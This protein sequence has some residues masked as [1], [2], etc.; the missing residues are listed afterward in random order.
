MATYLMSTTVIPASAFGAW[1]MD[2]IALEDLQVLLH[3]E[4]AGAGYTSAVGHESTAQIMAELLG[5]PVAAN[6]ITVEPKK[7]DVFYCFKLD[8]RPPEGA[9]LDRSQ[10]E[11]LGYSWARMHYIG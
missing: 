10:L 9:I 2:P 7:G 6:R 1:R 3:S 8:R 4:N 11:K 5:L